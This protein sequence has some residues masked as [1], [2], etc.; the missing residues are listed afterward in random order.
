MP[1]WLHKFFG[2]VIGPIIFN[3]EGRILC[4]P[5]IFNGMSK[6]FSSPTFW[7]HPPEPVASLSSHRFDPPALYRPRIFLWLPHF[8]VQELRCPKC[9]TG[10]LEKNGAYLP[11]RVIDIEDSFYVVS[12]SYYCRKGCQSHFRGWNPHLLA[13]LPPYLRLAFPA[14][15]SRKSGLS[16]R[17]ISQLRVGNQHKMGPSGVRSVLFEMH[18]HRFNV[19]QVQYA[20]AVF[21][22]VRGRQEMVSLAQPFLHAYI[23]S[24]IPTFGDFS[25]PEKYAGFVPSEFYLA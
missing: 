8:F 7:I 11:R 6:P 20:E 21:E 19:L 18:T 16:H 3:K 14:V 12:W 25:D 10:I 2:E 23:S 13:S 9:R 22:L 24:P 17:V 1:H 15:L 4:R 5:A